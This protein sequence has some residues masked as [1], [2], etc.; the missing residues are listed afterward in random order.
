MNTGNT[1]DNSTEEL[2]ELIKDCMLR[3]NNGEVGVDARNVANTP[4]RNFE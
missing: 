4:L 1:H 3:A 2:Q